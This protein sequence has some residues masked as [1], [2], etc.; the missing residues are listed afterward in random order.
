[1][2]R[3][4]F[5]KMHGLGNDF[6]VV[7]GMDAELDR[8]RVELLVPRVCKRNTGV[9]ADGVLFITEGSSG[10][11]FAMSVYNADGSLAEMCGNGLRCVALWAALRGFG[12]NDVFRIET[13]AGVLSASV[14][15]K[16]ENLHQGLVRVSLG[17]PQFL[18]GDIPMKGDPSS[19]AEPVFTFDGRE[20]AGCCVS[21][22][23]PH[24]V[25]RLENLAELRQFPVKRYARVVDNSGL[26]PEGTNIEFVA[27]DS[28]NVIYQR[29]WERGCG[30]TEACGTGAA[31][32][33][34][35]VRVCQDRSQEVEIVEPVI[36]SLPGGRVSIEWGGIGREVFLEGPAV[37]VFEGIL[38]D[39]GA[40]QRTEVWG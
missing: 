11:D 5:V 10:A 4:P 19:R 28:S 25:I 2:D 20:F 16:D 12:S 24:C 29:T 36:V 18:R 13:D 22:G 33:V 21:L 30:E 27:V 32:A 8:S 6:I 17:Y 26:F 14:L 34:I 35:A 23:N 9:G 7:N 15:E 39:N 37:Q 31:A 38:S 3:L 1:M 40:Y